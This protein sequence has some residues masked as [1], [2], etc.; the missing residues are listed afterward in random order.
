M[1]ELHCDEDDECAES[2]TIRLFSHSTA[3]ILKKSDFLRGGAFTS[4]ISD[5][6]NSLEADPGPTLGIH[7]RDVT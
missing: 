2:D 3:E 5:I 4:L 6:A 7:E 1:F